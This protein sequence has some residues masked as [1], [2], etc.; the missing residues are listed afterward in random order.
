VGPCLDKREGE[1]V[2]W[3]TKEEGE[4]PQAMKRGEGAACCLDG[5]SERAP[6]LLT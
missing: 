5:G 3:Y 2:S 4:E 1:V 6:E